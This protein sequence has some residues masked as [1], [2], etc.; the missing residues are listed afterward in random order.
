M[1]ELV[2]L[3]TSTSWP[4]PVPTAPADQTNCN[5]KLGFTPE[6]AQAPNHENAAAM[7]EMPRCVAE[8]GIPA[9]R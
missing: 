8:G 3:F 5:V 2:R 7:L 4:A 9:A 1:Y 6:I